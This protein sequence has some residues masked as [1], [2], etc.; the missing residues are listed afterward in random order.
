MAREAV[1][2][3][4]VQLVLAGHHHRSFSGG[5]PVSDLVAARSILVVQAGTAIST[6]LR[7]E[8]NSYNLLRL[9]QNHLSCTVLVLREGRFVNAETAE[10]SCAGE[11]WTRQ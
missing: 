8:P 2:Q 4:G 9:E 5:L 1:M 6:R 3:A 10:Y 11:R 7:A